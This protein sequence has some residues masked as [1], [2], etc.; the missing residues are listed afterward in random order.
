MKVL[1]IN[2]GSSSLKYQLVDMDTKQMLCKGLAERIGIEGGCVTHKVGDKSFTKEGELPTH[3]EAFTIMLDFMTKG[4]GAVVKDKSEIDAIGH[5]VVHGG[6]KFTGS[7]LVT[8]EVIATLEE[9]SPLAPLHNPPQV[10]G[11]RSAQKVFGEGVPEVAVFDTSFHQTMPAYAYM[12]AIPYKFYEENGVR[13]YGFHG[14]SHR[15]VSAKAAEY[16]GKDIHDLKIVTCHLGNGSSITAV[17]HGQS[18]DTSMGLTPLGGLMMGTRCGDLDP[19]VATYLAELTGRTGNNLAKLLNTESGFLGVSGISSDNR[20][21]EQAA[22]VEGNDRALLVHDMFAY[23]IKKFIGAYTAAMNG[24]DAIVFTGG[25]GENSG[26][27]RADVAGGL[28]YLGVD[29][30]YEVNKQHCAD[31]LDVTAPNA[32]VKTLVIATNEELM[33]AQD[34]AEIVAAL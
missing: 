9:L 33:I 32:T 16:I 19:S 17:D 5:R 1:V 13:R 2:S 34:T 30:D 27:L 4:D 23:Q 3:A 22:Q 7:V 11:I 12:F 29:I 18:V 28:T 8:D 31:V 26:V 6:E 24:V 15:Y 14:T 25:I 20:D 21:I 10:M